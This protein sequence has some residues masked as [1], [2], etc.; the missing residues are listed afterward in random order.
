MVRNAWWVAVLVGWL[1]VPTAGWA[2]ACVFTSQGLAGTLREARSEADFIYLAR[3]HDPIDPS[4]RAT[5]LEV[6]ESFKGTLKAGDVLRLPFEG[7]GDCSL[8]VEPGLWLF[9]AYGNPEGVVKCSRSRPVLPDDSEL[10]WLRTGLLPPVPVSLQR[11]VASCE[12][13]EIEAIG[14][15]LLV[16]P[17]MPPAERTTWGNGDAM[18]RWKAGQPFFTYAGMGGDRVLGVSREGRAF[19]LTEITDESPERR[20]CERRIQLRWCKRLEFQK[21]SQ[22]TSGF[23]CVEPGEPQDV[24]DE[25]PSRKVQWLPMER[26]PP[27]DCRWDKPAEPFC[28]LSEA[29]F[30]FPSGSPALPVLACHALSPGPDSGA[31]RCEVKTTPESV[32]PEP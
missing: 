14:G 26:L 9:Y 18:A 16:S 23:R 13:C 30:P 8:P 25:R 22:S 21:E 20:A 12:V 11:E 10:T 31:F 17:G 24:C 5:S 28:Y 7:Q 6:L 29:R 32:P 2:C 19:A 15:R 3:V 27:G 1:A 4:P